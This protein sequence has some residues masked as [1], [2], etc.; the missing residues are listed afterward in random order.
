MGP[1]PIY[2]RFSGISHNLLLLGIG[3]SLI[4]PEYNMIGPGFA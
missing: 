4:S 1:I 2:L 3:F